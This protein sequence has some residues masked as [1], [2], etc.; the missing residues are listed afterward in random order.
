MKTHF[1]FTLI[2]L[3]PI[4]AVEAQ[5][6]YYSYSVKIGTYSPHDIKSSYFVGGTFKFRFTDTSEIGA[7][8]DL[9]R[10]INR[11]ETILDEN[12]HFGQITETEIQTNA[13]KVALILPVYASFQVRNPIFYKHYYYVSGTVGYNYLESREKVYSEEISRLSKK[14]HGMRYSIES[15]FI[16]RLN[17]AYGFIIELSYIFSEVSRRKVS[18]GAPVKG[19]VNLSGFTFRIGVRR[20]FY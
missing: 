6:A 9:Y 7:G 3:L 1:I 17:H 8:I 15:G 13:E 4:I 16:Y 10:C 20:G 12:I 18:I 2:F 19:V 14:Y 5:P 11:D